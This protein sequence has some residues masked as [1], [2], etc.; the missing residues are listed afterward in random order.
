MIIRGAEAIARQALSFAASGRV[1]HPVLVNGAAGVVVTR[2][3]RPVSV[4]GFTVT[5]GRIV[6]IDALT[7]RDRL[8]RLDLAV[9]D[10]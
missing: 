3:G 8:S 7:D 1:V 10:G 6:A 2:S 9:L 4:M 5:D